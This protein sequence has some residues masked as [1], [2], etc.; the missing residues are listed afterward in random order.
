M[1]DWMESAYATRVSAK[2]LAKKGP[3]AQFKAPTGWY[4][5]R[6]VNQFLG[7]RDWIARHCI[8]LK[9]EEVLQGSIL[10]GEQLCDVFRNFNN[11]NQFMVMVKLAKHEQLDNT[12]Y[13]N[14]DES[15]F[16]TGILTP[17]ID[18]PVRLKVNLQERIGGKHFRGR[19][20]KKPNGDDFSQYE[21]FIL[22]KEEPSSFQ[23]HPGD[24]IRDIKF[25][26]VFGTSHK[27]RSGH[28]RR[29]CDT[30]LNKDE[31]HAWLRHIAFGQDPKHTMKLVKKGAS[32]EELPADWE[33]KVKD[34]CRSGAIT[35]MPLRLEQEEAII[36]AFKNRWSQIQGPPGTGKTTVALAVIS[37]C[38]ELGM[39]YLCM[40][41]SS[42]AIDVL[43]QKRCQK[44]GQ[45][46]DQI[47]GIYRVRKTDVKHFF[48]DVAFDAGYQD[49]ALSISREINRICRDGGELTFQPLE[50]DQ[51]IINRLRDYFEH[52][53]NSTHNATEP[54]YLDWHYDQHF[55][56]WVEMA[57][58]MI[59]QHSR[60]VF[61]TIAD[62]LTDLLQR[63]DATVLL[64]DEA[65]HALEPR[66]WM[67]IFA[68]ANRGRITSIILLG[69]HKQ[70]PP[71][72]I[73]EMNFFK[74]QGE[75][76]LLERLTNL[77]FE[78][79]MLLQQFRMHPDISYCPNHQ[80]YNGRIRDD[81]ST[82]TQPGLGLFE[83]F[84]A[85]L[86]DLN[87]QTLGDENLVL[88]T[89][90]K[91]VLFALSHHKGSFHGIKQRYGSHSWFNEQADANC[92]SLADR[93]IR[94]HG[95]KPGD[96]AIICFYKD[97]AEL[98]SSAVRDIP[99]W[100]GNAGERGL[101][102][103][104]VDQC[105]GSEWMFTIVNVGHPGGKTRT[106]Y[107][108]TS[109]NRWNVACTRAMAGQVIVGTE[110]FVKSPYL[111]SESPWIFQWNY[112][113]E[114]NAIVSDAGLWEMAEHLPVNAA[115]QF[116]KRFKDFNVRLVQ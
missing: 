88:D 51:E 57:K 69:D 33:R 79:S 50:F 99:E 19:V 67:A 97:D 103:C 90:R 59:L 24:W 82:R 20:V 22:V 113:R 98:L 13:D 15:A 42:S 6:A 16:E 77:K 108:E 89:K 34:F 41:D 75:Q 116:L 109:S 105:Q 72:L 43:A 56:G 94:Y 14:S 21:I 96:V 115:K 54:G 17:E 1:P 101:T 65:S 12:F 93:L 92:I 60:G 100:E 39:R 36:R 84:L 70:L 28:M 64:I 46:L 45:N 44:D 110:Y 23:G 4:R 38:E 102:V 37:L 40:A 8:G 80:M 73:S 86:N 107:L 29:L 18:T 76:S 52:K 85:D 27:S 83:K 58:G 68:A 87:Q 48:D 55:S 106:G 7:P 30:I 10:N 62:A 3:N 112:L 2:K 66:V 32:C 95:A 74:P 104:T 71:T 114:T 63:Y 78:T 31:E 49:Y 25:K 111:N 9:F 35:G 26:L 81:P 91:S 11:D 5:E 61:C 47:P 53:R